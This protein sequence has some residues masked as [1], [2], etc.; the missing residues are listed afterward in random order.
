MK[1]YLKKIFDFFTTLFLVSLLTFFIFQ[2]LPGNPALSILGPDADSATLAEFEAKMGLDKSLL[3]RYFSWILGAFHGDLGISYRYNIPVS[4]LIQGS[5]SATLSL[6]VVALIFTALIGFSFGF[7][8][9]YISKTPFFKPLKTIHHIWFSIPSFCTALFLI[10][11]FAVVLPIFPTMGYVPLSQN[12]FG[13]FRSLFLPALSL[14]LGSG[15]I[16]SRYVTTSILGE[17]KQDYV[18]T[19]RSK[20]LSESLVIRRHILRNALLPSVTA[21]GLIMVEIL[22]GSII[23]ENVFSIPGIGR[24]IASSILTRDFPLIQGL[25][26]YLAFITL[27][28]N[29]LVDILYS[30]I[31]PRI[32]ISGKSGSEGL[33]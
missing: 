8:F 16:L 32:R 31:D 22:G 7:F 12:F 11:I 25:V 21:L 6:A 26:L 28:C 15:A 23:I 30:L 1:F 29:V 19:A 27:F 17:A 24:L 2:F 4:H 9:A 14:A 3:E 18:R 5:F 13:W 20:G 33:S 10:L